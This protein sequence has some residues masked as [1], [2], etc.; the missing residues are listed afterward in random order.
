MLDNLYEDVCRFSCPR[1]HKITIK[2]FLTLKCSVIMRKKRKKFT[3]SL[4]NG[5]SNEPK[6]PIISLFCIL[7]YVMRRDS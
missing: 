6:Y 1:G 5:Y 7:L 4:I 3:F 2:A